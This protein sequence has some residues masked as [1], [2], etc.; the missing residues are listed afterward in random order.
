MTPPFRSVAVWFVSVL[1]A[2]S[3]AFVIPQLA[4]SFAASTAS[5]AE[6]KDGA[7]K[8]RSSCFRFVE[9]R[10][11]KRPVADVPWSSGMTM[12][13]AGYDK[14]KESLQATS[15]ESSLDV[16]LKSIKTRDL[17]SLIKAASGS[18]DS[19][20][21]DGY[22]LAAVLLLSDGDQGAASHLLERAK[23]QAAGVDD[24]FAHWLEL[25]G[26]EMK[27]PEPKPQ[28]EAKKEPEGG[29]KTD[30]AGGET[31]PG[32]PGSTKLPTGPGSKKHAV[33]KEHPRLFGSKQRLQGLMQERAYGYGLMADYAKKKDAYDPTAMPAMALVSCLENDKDLAREAIKRAMVY[34]TGPIKVGHVTF[35]HDLAYSA[36]VYDLCHPYWTA[37]EKTK[38]IDYMNKTVDANVGSETYPYHNGY[39][40]YKNW[41]IGLACYA[42]MYEN[43]RAAE[44]LATLDA[45]FRARAVPCLEHAGDGGAWSEGHYI[46]YWIYEWLVFC[47]VARM[48]EGVDYYPLAPKF[49]ANRAVASMFQ[50]LP[51]HLPHETNRP[52]PDGDGGYG[53]YGGFSEKILSA[54]RILVNYY[55]NDPVH[56]MVHAY[57]Q[58]VPH[59][60]IPESYG[61]MD[62]LWND[63]SVTKGDLKQMKLSHFAPGAGEVFARNSWDGDSTYFFFKCGDRISAHQQLDV[64]HFFIYRQEHLAG[65]SG[66]YD[67]FDSNHCVNYYIRSIA[68]NTMLV[69][70][71]AEKFPDGIRAGPASANDG[72]QAYPWK[73]TAMGHNA[74]CL[75][76]PMF[77]ANK[78]LADIADVLAYEDHGS[79]LYTAGDCTRAYSSAKMALFTRQ[80]VFIRPSTIVIFDRVKATK[81]D[82]KKTWVLNLHKTPTGTAPTMVSTNGNGKLFIQTVLPANADITLHSGAELYAYEG[83]SFPPNPPAA[84]GMPIVECRMEVSPKTASASDLFLHVLTATDAKTDTAAKAEAKVTG[85]DVTVT[86]GGA[87]IKFDVNSV[88]GTIVVGGQK[89]TL[90][91]KIQP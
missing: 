38:F 52:V 80:I 78:Q 42:T 46:H 74:G 77:T 82:Y 56:Q 36:M 25:L 75:D 19:P 17:A 27:A 55:R 16:P 89:G 10:L 18:E 23:T 2:L 3:C 12:T 54:R 47:E 73:G 49:F 67:A 33:S 43:P 58:L 41:G 26:L 83:K 34:A 6:A 15:G 29:D 53:T 13:F 11:A 48:C 72:G 8:L 76:F 91:N 21:A 57:N 14:A 66:V 5:G 22:I 62:F 44:I 50:M 85:S 87:V 88:G 35:G 71:P 30:I 20:D 4:L 1:W 28:P 40:G 7:E 51:G 60:C 31:A 64:G 45:D 63:L 37:D 59:L 68:H 32:I 9:R 69:Y 81:P 61:Y 79:W 65:D 84:A 86:V 90:A 24:S 39:Y 70:D